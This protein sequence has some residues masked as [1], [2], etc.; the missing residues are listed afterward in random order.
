[1]LWC[2]PTPGYTLGHVPCSGSLSGAGR[3]SILSASKGEKQTGGHGT[4]L[5]VT[6]EACAATILQCPELVCSDIPQRGEKDYMSPGSKGGLHMHM[7]MQHAAC[8]MLHAA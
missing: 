6:W 5:H 8:C 2:A 1:M 4:S 3:S 7:H